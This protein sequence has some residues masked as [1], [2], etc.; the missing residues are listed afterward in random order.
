MTDSVTEGLVDAFKRTTAALIVDEESC[1]PS[2]WAAVKDAANTCE[3]VRIAVLAGH[4]PELG[5]DELFAE[6]VEQTELMLTTYAVIAP[7]NPAIVAAWRETYAEW[8]TRE[9]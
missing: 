3:A 8:I 6:L 7:D 9:G 1:A 4:A 5:P 2:D